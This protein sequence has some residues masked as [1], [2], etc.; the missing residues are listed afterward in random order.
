MVFRRA[1]RC[2]TLSLLVLSCQASAQSRFI[3]QPKQTATPSTQKVSEPAVAS[4][5]SNSAKLDPKAGVEPG[6]NSILEQSP[7]GGE[8]I[9]WVKRGSVRQQR[10]QAFAN[11][12]SQE[13]SSRAGRVGIQGFPAKR[14]TNGTSTITQVGKSVRNFGADIPTVSSPVGRTFM[15]NA[16]PNRELASDQQVSLQKQQMAQTV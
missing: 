12:E 7:F 13:L 6:I 16:I 4:Q 1:R 15:P 9:Q 2:A 14:T 3:V 11:S 5:V 10:S 8:A